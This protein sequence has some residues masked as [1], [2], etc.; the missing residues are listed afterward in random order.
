LF[1]SIFMTLGLGFTRPFLD[2]VLVYIN[3]LLL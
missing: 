3:R 2:R 1:W